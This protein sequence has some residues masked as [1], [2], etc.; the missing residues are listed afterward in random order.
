MF[1]VPR[2]AYDA[3]NNRLLYACVALSLLLHS[4]LALYAPRSPPRV[5]EA[6]SR[7]MATLRAEPSAPLTAATPAPAASPISPAA[8]QTPEPP[9]TRVPSSPTPLASQRAVPVPRAAGPS[10]P[11][12]PESRPL[13]DPATH[14]ERAPDAPA[15][16]QAGVPVPAA[17][18]T[19][20]PVAAPVAPAISVPETRSAQGADARAEREAP[21][22]ARASAQAGEVTERELVGFYQ[23]QLAGIIETRKLKRYPGEAMQNGWEGT[24]TVLLHIGTDGKVAGVETDTS[25]GYAMLD[26]QARISIARAKPFV[27]IPEGLRGRAFDA[28]VRVVFSLAK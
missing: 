9:P 20:G 22:P 21:R 7:I 26:E 12:R 6:P 27:Q 17:P 13:P 24:S 23:S 5:A 8:V 10:V 11:P 2:E 28:R 25:S 4:M 1:A 3:G 19:P 16:P 18:A 15:A 14:V